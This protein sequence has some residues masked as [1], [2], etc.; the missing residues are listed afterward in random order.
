MDQE[1]KQEFENLAL[2][3]KDGFDNT[4][5]KVEL[6]QLKLDLLDAMDDKLADLKGDLVILM[7]KGDHKLLRLVEILKGKNILAENE[8][9]EIFTMEPFPKLMA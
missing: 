8:V 4:A 7:R 9:K 6:G 2:M 3:I 1:T 5:T